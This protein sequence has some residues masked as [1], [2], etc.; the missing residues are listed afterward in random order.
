MPDVSPGR[1]DPVQRDDAPPAAPVLLSER[2][3]VAALWSFSH[4]GDPRQ[5]RR[6]RLLPGGG[7]GGYLHPNEA[8][9]R[10]DEGVLVLL[11]HAGIP[12][13]RFEQ[14]E[15]AS[16]GRLVLEGDFLLDP[17]ARIRLRLE[18]HRWDGWHDFPGMTRLRLAR[19]IDAMSWTV[20]D[21]TYGQPLVYANGPERLHIGRYTSIAEQVTIVLTNHR[22]EFVSTYPFALLREHWWSVGEQ[23]SD[24]RGRGDVWIGSD[25]WIGHGAL[26]SAGVRIG[27]G[28]VIGSQAVVT[29]DVA[30]Y[31]VV[32]GSPAKVVKRRFEPH[33]V[34]ALLRI[35]WWNWPDHKVDRYLPLILS[36]DISAF[37]AAAQADPD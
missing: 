14:A 31:S 32:V 19:Q 25:V 23:V 8:A 13:T 24:H 11:D 37:I 22:P 21:H 7:V 9:W 10:I 5:G 15:Q 27:D 17:A 35:A 29:K 18:E 12:S 3:L 1:T 33:V 28:A 6:L 30:P 4:V 20:G 34:D 36:P 16:D 26:I 2:R